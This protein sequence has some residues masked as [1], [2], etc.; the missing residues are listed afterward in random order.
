MSRRDELITKHV[1]KKGLRGK[2]DAHCISCVYDEANKGT[3]RQ[4]IE[5]CTVTTCPL[6]SVRKMTLKAPLNDVPRDNQV[7]IEE[8]L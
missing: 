7:D 8:L 1:Q 2:V 4:Q 3:W 6:Y 5:W